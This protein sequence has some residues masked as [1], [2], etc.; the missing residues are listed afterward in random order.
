MSCI[1]FL[2]YTNQNIISNYGVDVSIFDKCHRDIIFGKVKIC[3]PLT[4]VYICAKSG[5]TVKQI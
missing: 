5:C 3:V 2:F 1:D 4:P